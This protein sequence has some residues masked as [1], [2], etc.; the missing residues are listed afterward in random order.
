MLVISK[1]GRGSGPSINN[2]VVR[3]FYPP[4]IFPSAS[5]ARLEFHRRLQHGSTRTPKFVPSR[6]LVSSP[7]FLSSNHPPYLFLVSLSVSLP[8]FYTLSPLFYSPIPLTVSLS[9][10][11]PLSLFLT[12]SLSL[13]VLPCFFGYTT[14]AA[15]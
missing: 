12:L 10:A 4:A 5:S 7:Y 14:V 11:V 15:R 9:R 2:S 1:S 8:R 6:K 13:R 3:V